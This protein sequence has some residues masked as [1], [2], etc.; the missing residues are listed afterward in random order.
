MANTSI[1]FYPIAV[2]LDAI[3]LENDTLTPMANKEINLDP[4]LLL[5]LPEKWKIASAAVDLSC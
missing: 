5:G 1:V 4:T 2:M 3:N